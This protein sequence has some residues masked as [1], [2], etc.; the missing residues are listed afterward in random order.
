M[1]AEIVATGE[2]IRTGALIDSNSAYIAA[3]LEENGVAV[4]RH[5][6]VG[7]DLDAL[8]AVLAE[9]GRRAHLAVVANSR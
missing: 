8:T 1:N 6:G 2:E 5:I 7:D 9:V 4:T 3:R